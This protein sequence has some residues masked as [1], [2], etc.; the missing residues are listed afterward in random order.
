[1][2]VSKSSVSRR[3]A[4]ASGE[5]LKELAERQLDSE[6]GLTRPL[7]RYLGNHAPH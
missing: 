2:G 4:E 5:R 3:A 1:M 7:R 6:L